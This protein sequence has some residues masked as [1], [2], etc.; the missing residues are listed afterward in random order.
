[1]PRLAVTGVV[2]AFSGCFGYVTFAMQSPVKTPR[3]P[4]LFG[5]PLDGDNH[6]DVARVSVSIGT[7]SVPLK[8]SP[9]SRGTDSLRAGHSQAARELDA[10]LAQLASA[11]SPPDLPAASAEQQPCSQPVP[12]SHVLVVSMARTA[13]SGEQSAVRD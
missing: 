13:R 10:T 1:M 7:V 6:R 9:G 12:S 3:L 2:G 11:Y 5:R 4:P 8:T